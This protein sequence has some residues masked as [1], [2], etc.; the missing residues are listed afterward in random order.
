[1]HHAIAAA[2]SRGNNILADHVFVEKAWVD[3]CAALFAEMNAYLIGLNCPQYTQ[4]DLELDTS[5]LTTEECAEQ[6]I[7]RLKFPPT[8]FDGLQRL[9][10]LQ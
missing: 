7:E 2:A 9:L 4:Y 8:A 10:T 3:E 5:K 1:M 6:V